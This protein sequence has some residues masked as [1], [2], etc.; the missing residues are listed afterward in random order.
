MDIYSKHSFYT[1]VF[2]SSL[3]YVSKERQKRKKE[4]KKE[5]TNERTKKERIEEG[6][7]KRKYKERSLTDMTRLFFEEL[8]CE[9]L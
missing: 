4:G 3:L 6:S 8:R 7:K 2:K 1:Y 5:W 9:R